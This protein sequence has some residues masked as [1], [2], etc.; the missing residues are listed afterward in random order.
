MLNMIPSSPPSSIHSHRDDADAISAPSSSPATTLTS[1]QTDADAAENSILAV[2]LLADIFETSPVLSSTDGHSPNH[3]SDVNDRAADLELNPYGP[4]SERGYN[5][6]PDIELSDLPYLRRQHVTA[7][8]RDGVTFS[9]TKNVQKGFDQGFPVGAQLG[10]RAGTILGILEGLTKGLEAK[11]TSGRVIK[12]GLF[13]TKD[14]VTSDN[15]N[16]GRQMKTLEMVRQL[17]YDASQ[18]LK[19]ELLFGSTST[20]QTGDD[21]TQEVQKPELVLHKRA[22]TV[23]SRWEKK[24]AVP[25][26]EECMAMI[27]DEEADD[28]PPPS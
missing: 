22:E 17:H 6:Q 18:E 3:G 4:T 19:I 21:T 20:N 7:G 13:A 12:K 5:R 8:Y 11:N 25:E 28:V 2:D 24:L 14:T 23:L 16:K 1:A 15:A 9:K 27:E 26:W 10:L